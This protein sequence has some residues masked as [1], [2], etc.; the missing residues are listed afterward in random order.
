[1]LLPFSHIFLASKQIYNIISQQ[2]NTKETKPNKTNS[3]NPV[4][5]REEG[6]ERGNWVRS[7]G[8]ITRRRRRQ[9]RKVEVRA[10]TIRLGSS[11]MGL[12]RRDQIDDGFSW[13]DQTGGAMGRGLD[14][15]FT[16]DSSL[17]PSAWAWCE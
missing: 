2:I 11:E 14:L 5:L 16:S 3:S 13:R 15:G 7:R 6:R 8:K 4:K 9:D 10:S 12:R 17:R 1:M